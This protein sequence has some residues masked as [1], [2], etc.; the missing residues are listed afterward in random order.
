[1]HAFC[2]SR[3]GPGLVGD[4]APV[5]PP[6]VRWRTCPAD[7]PDTT[8][9][10][11]GRRLSRHR[12]PDPYRPLEDSDAPATREWI[13]AQNA[14]TA[15]VLGDDPAR[16][17]IRER[18]AELWDFPRA[19]APWRRGDRWFQLRNTGLQDQDVLWTADGPDGEGSVLLDPNRLGA[20][21]TTAL[22]AVDGLRER[23]SRRLRDVGRRLRLAHLDGATRRD[24]RGAARPDPVGQV[25]ARG[26]DARRRRLLLRALPG[27]ARRRRLRRAQP[28]H[29]AALPPSRHGRRRRSPRL[30]DARSTPSG[31]STTSRCPRTAGCWW[32]PW[33]TAPTRRTGSTSPTW[34]TAWRRAVVRPLLD[35]AD[36]H[37][38][39]IATVDRDALPAHRPRCAARSRDR[40]RRGRPRAPARDRRRGR[41]HARAR[42]PRRG[43]ARG[44]LPPPRPPPAR[45][46]RAR[47]APRRRRAAA[48]RSARSSTWRAGAPTTSC[49]SRS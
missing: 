14:L 16:G 10:R 43:P 30:R 35:A 33:R 39:H 9:R 11:P 37:Y 34:P 23:R 45:H 2:G 44:G 36:A 22:A 32:S 19:G 25:R 26:M 38:E 27:A 8:D 5:G 4:A 28:G 42:A 15:R 20:Q 31:S 41:G 6:A 21:G 18:L 24:R 17:A 47:R 49:T 48:R 29:G 40:R 1:M 13:A 7:V 3:H 12:D 46:L